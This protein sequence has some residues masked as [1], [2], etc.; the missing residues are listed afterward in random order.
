[1]PN[2]LLN[3]IAGMNYYYRYYP[4][5]YFLQSLVK[6]NISQFE[7][8][9]ATQ[10]F[11]VDDHGYQNVEKFIEKI[12]EYELKIICLTPEQSNPKPYS[13]TAAEPHLKVKAEKYFKNVIKVAKLLNC[14]IV[15]FN[16][17]WAYYSEDIGEAWK[18]S[19]EMMRKLSYY[20]EKQG[21]GLVVEALQ[22]NESPLV[23]SIADLQK[24]ISEVGSSNLNI[25]LDLGAMARQGETIQDYFD[26]FGSRI[27]HCHFV[28]GAPSGHLA[29]GDG[30]R[31]VVNDLKVLSSNNYQGYLSFEFAQE[32]YF[33]DPDKV[34][35]GTLQYIKSKIEK[36]IEK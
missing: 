17:G 35:E 12:K 29:W 25:N 11:M 26:A 6:N 30:Q 5:D 4:I 31:D 21:V 15:G 1:M 16:A 7:L 28:D 2:N 33:I 13:L 3:R 22:P 9:M 24:Y 20:A 34:D 32:K 18:R 10:H 19:V 27:K 23:N 8:W 14:P 36:E